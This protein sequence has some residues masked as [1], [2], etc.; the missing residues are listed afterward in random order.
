MPAGSN[1]AAEN[2]VVGEVG[3][4]GVGVHQGGD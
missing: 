1:D 3:T 4:L 2:L